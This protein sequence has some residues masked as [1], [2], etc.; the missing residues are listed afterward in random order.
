MKRLLRKLDR[1]LPFSSESKSSSLC[2][3]SLPVAVESDLLYL[4][5]QSS[6]NGV[7]DQPNAPIGRSRSASGSEIAPV[8]SNALSESETLFLSG[9]QHF[10]FQNSFQDN[11]TSYLPFLLRR[12]RLEQHRD[13]DLGYWSG[14][15]GVPVRS[16]SL[17]PHLN[18]RDP[19]DEHTVALSVH[20]H[21]T[22]M[23]RDI[24]AYGAKSSIVVVSELIKN[25]VYVFP[26]EES[27]ALF[28]QLRLGRKS[29]RRRNSVIVYDEK[30]NIIRIT[31]TSAD[32]LRPN[33]TDTVV[34]RRQH[35]IPVDSK[36]KGTGLPL[37]KVVVPYMSSFRRKAPFMVFR[38]YRE[39]PERPASPGADDE[40]FETYVFCEVYKKS[41][42]PYKRYAFKFTPADSPLFTLYAFQY[43]YRPFADFTYKNT[44]FRILG[45]PVLLVYVAVCSPELRLCVLD[46]L[47]PSLADDLVEREQRP[48]LSSRVRSHSIPNMI[49]CLLSL[50][51]HSPPLP[52]EPAILLKDPVPRPDNPIVLE[53][54]LFP[55]ANDHTFV[56]YNFPPFARFMD[57]FVYQ[58]NALLL[59][60]KYTEVGKIEVYQD[61]LESRALDPL[62]TY[63]VEIDQLVLSTLLLAFRE[64]KIRVAR[65]QL[66]Y[67]PNSSFMFNSFS[68]PDMLGFSGRTV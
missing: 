64:A 7:V 44:R 47:Q 59:P 53:G 35:I 27:F 20:N 40:H 46:D 12:L 29:E 10:Q 22:I 65:R 62:T 43:S 31:S 16:D 23:G 49:L 68:M 28:K 60:K 61:P 17:N 11:Y 66:S 67:F 36:I 48:D 15:S 42:L 58:K 1:S 6:R 24:V 4:F 18:E 33:T 19:D 38:K 50:E 26:S 5:E 25:S 30:S 21:R 51:L 63:A 52:S 57:S 9:L 45:T 37:F 14:V 39:I 41:F 2:R 3:E 13:L 55:C 32:A 54:D 56:P 34:D 8:R